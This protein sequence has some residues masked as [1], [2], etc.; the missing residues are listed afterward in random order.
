MI[1]HIVA[2]QWVNYDGSSIVL[3]VNVIILPVPWR[4]T[5]CQA[6]LQYRNGLFSI[7]KIDHGTGTMV[8][9]TRYQVPSTW[10]RKVW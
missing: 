1:Q 2:E 3:T 4:S 9:G 8:P 5:G 10:S 6:V 7:A